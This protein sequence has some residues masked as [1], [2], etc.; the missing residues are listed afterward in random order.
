[1]FLVNDLFFLNIEG[2]QDGGKNSE[3]ILLRVR[4]EI[5]KSQANS[6]NNV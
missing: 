1:M 3:E 5:D 2:G 4:I 6:M